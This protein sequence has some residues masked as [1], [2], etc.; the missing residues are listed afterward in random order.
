MHLTRRSILKMVGLGVAST[1]L[2]G[3][4]TSNSGWFNPA[5]S[6]DAANLSPSAAGAIAG[7]IVP[8]LAENV[9][10]GTGTIYLKADNSE[11]G[12][13]LESALRGWGYAVAAADQQ[14]SGDS[15]IPLAYAVDQDGNEILVRITTPQVE[16]SR[17]YIASA[18]GA[19]PSSALAVL[20]RA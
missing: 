3:C 10:P 15:I 13:A 7:D 16:L 19:N 6:A 2:A 8:K 18:E 9:G 20:S 17:T 12:L 14:P 11:F 4:V 5:T 1:P